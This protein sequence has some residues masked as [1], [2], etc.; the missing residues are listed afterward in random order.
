[1][2][3]TAERVNPFGGLPLID[4]AISQSSS[5]HNVNGDRRLL[6]LFFKIVQNSKL[7]RLYYFVISAWLSARKLDLILDPKPRSN[8]FKGLHFVEKAIVEFTHKLLDHE[9]A[10][11]IAETE[12]FNQDFPNPRDYDPI[13]RGRTWYDI[14]NITPE[15]QGGNPLLWGDG[16]TVLAEELYTKVVTRIVDDMMGSEALAEWAD[17]LTAIGTEVEVTS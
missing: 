8:L 7:I 1:M 14:L 4:Y 6:R 15:N 10:P 3:S 9:P 2:F 17:S 16:F 12:A 13:E 5:W 11:P